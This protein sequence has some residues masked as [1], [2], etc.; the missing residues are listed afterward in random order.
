MGLL[1][2]YSSATGNT[3]H[4]VE[5]LGQKLL[6]LDKT[7]AA[8][9]IREPYVL[10]VPTYAGSEGQG[11]VPKTVIRF[12]NEPE[13]RKWLRGVIAGGNRNFGWTY[14]LAGK[15]IAEKCNVPCLYR[16]ELRGT[17]ED[18]SLV[19]QGLENLWNQN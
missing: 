11:A 17:S 1:V 13:N 16:F 19:I 18:V 8:P 10:V 2:Y 15:V 7:A 9:L 6:R 12:L 14:A 4:F 3:H 5:Q